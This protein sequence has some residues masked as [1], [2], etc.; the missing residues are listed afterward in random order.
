MP[1]FLKKFLLWLL[2]TYRQKLLQ[3]IVRMCYSKQYLRNFFQNFHVWVY[4]GISEFVQKI[5]TIFCC[6]MRNNLRQ[7]VQVF[8]RAFI[9]EFLQIASRG[10][11]FTYLF[12]ESLH[13]IVK[14]FF[15][16]KNRFQF[17]RKFLLEIRTRN[18]WKNLRNSI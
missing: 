11:C 18:I 7:L 8:S 3:K 15:F 4:P 5:L 2:R 14:I 6:E 16:S 13:E 1:T 9:H 17:V 10:I 12:Q